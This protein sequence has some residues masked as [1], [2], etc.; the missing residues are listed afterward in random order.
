MTYQKDVRVVTGGLV[1]GRTVKVPLLQLGHGGGRLVE[2][3][4]L[5]PETAIAVNPDVYFISSI[6]AP[7]F[8]GISLCL[9][10]SLFE[11]CHWR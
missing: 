10:V 8:D 5:T 4:G 3:H 2:G 7:H 6:R 1:G 11:S 9:L